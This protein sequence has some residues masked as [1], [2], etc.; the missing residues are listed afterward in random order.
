MAIYPHMTKRS[1]AAR[2]TYKDIYGHIPLHDKA[3]GGSTA[4]SL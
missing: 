3:V 4:D 1:V 2:Q